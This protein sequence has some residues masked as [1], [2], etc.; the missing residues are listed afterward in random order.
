MKPISIICWK[1]KD[2]RWPSSYGALQVN[3]LADSI[4]RNLKVPHKIFCITDD[5]TGL[6]RDI[7]VIPMW[8]DFDDLGHCYRRL[9]AFSS[10]MK[11]LIG[12]RFYSIDLDTVITGDLTELLTRGQEFV[13]ARDTQPGT[14]YN[15]S[16]WGM[17]AGARSLVYT[18]FKDRP[19]EHIT[20]AR[21]RGYAACDQAIMALIMGEREQTVGQQE[22][23]Y[24]FKNDLLKNH[25]GQLPDNA[26]MVFFHGDPK[27]W[28]YPDSP[29]VM[30]SW[31]NQ[32]YRRNRRGLL[33][34]GGSNCLWDDLKKVDVSQFDIMATNDTGHVYEGR[35]DYWATLHPENFPAWKAKRWGNVD[36]ESWSYTNYPV[37]KLNGV[38]EDFW[39]A[40]NGISGSTGLFAAQVGLHLGYD[41]VL[42]AGVPMDG[43]NNIM[44][45]KECW[46]DKTANSFRTAWEENLDRLREKVYS[47]SGWTRE[48]LGYKEFEL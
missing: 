14:P 18:E 2:D 36:Y 17:E 32:H 44:G 1:W 42:L 16:F 33:V 12:D 24:S 10:E 38:L 37:A 26:K 39:R 27:P 9:K 41:Y 48:L 43:G 31:I 7:G 35:I 20:D 8:K 15:G 13:I 34:L 11:E 5:P 19:Q 4:T 47:L 40:R 45:P 29:G 30:P 23:L 25:R 46:N 3:I 22:G 28:H 6:H 21:C